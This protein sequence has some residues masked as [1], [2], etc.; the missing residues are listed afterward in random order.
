MLIESTLT[1]SIV[2][3]DVGPGVG[4]PRQHD[5][6]KVTIRSVTNCISQ[7]VIW[8]FISDLCTLNYKQIYLCATI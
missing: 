5:I 3:G 4:S 7:A 1:I 2:D 8:N 6:Q